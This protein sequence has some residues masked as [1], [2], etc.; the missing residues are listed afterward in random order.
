MNFRVAICGEAGVGKSCLLETLESGR[1]KKVSQRQEGST[2]VKCGKKNDKTMNISF[3]KLEPD[4]VCHG[5]GWTDK[6]LCTILA[7]KDPK[8]K[9]KKEAVVD[10]V[11]YCIPARTYRANHQS[12]CSMT[13]VNSWLDC[14]QHHTA[15]NTPIAII[16]TKCD[17]ESC[18]DGDDEKSKSPAAD[19]QFTKDQG[20]K[21]VNDIDDICCCF[22]VSAMEGQGVKDFYSTV[23]S[24]LVKASGKGDG[25]VIC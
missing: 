1:F 4:I 22:D 14:I 6:E 15:K 8:K 11:C 12:V 21:L 19:L 9:D 2:N 3:F 10:G 20:D 23:G 16:R 25:C 24:A 18:G 5:T 17:L 7:G 13:S